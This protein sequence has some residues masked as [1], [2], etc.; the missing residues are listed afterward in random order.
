MFYNVHFFPVFKIL[1][2]F[3]LPAIKQVFSLF[4]YMFSV[5]S[6]RLA[7]T[8]NHNSFKKKKKGF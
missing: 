1:K 6:L 7:K 4:H 8:F 2:M 5:N 3:I